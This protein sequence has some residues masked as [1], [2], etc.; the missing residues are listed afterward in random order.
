MVNNGRKRGGRSGIGRRTFIGAAGAGAVAT[1]FAGCLG[2]DDDDIIRI[3]HLGPVQM[4]MGAGA[5]NSA[6][7]AVDQVNEDGGILDQEVELISED[8]LGDP[9]ESMTATER[10][11]E[12]ENIDVLIGTFVSEVTQGIVD[13]VGEVDIPFLIT[14]SADPIT[15]TDTVGEDY[16][17]FKNI[18]RSGPINSDLQALG[19][20]DYAEFLADEHGWTDFAH[21]ADD[22]AWTVPFSENLP[23]ELEDRGL[24]V[25]HEDRLAPGTDDFSPMLSDVSDADAD[26]MLRF[27]A[28][29][30]GTGMLVN[31]R[32]NEYEFGIEGIH[33]PGMSPEFWDDSE[34]AC[35]YETTSQSGAAGAAEITEETVPFTEAYVEEYGDSRPSLPM[36]M[37]YNSYDAVFVYKNAVE[38]A[39][40]ADYQ[41]DIDTI[42]DELLET[43]HTGATGE[44]EFYG[45]DSEYP[46]DV[47]ETEVDGTISNF[48][49]TQWQED[50]EFECVFPRDFASA[51][52][53][54][55]DWM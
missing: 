18:F 54:A 55:P 27:F 26:A 19:M 44:I 43:D 9:G 37:G 4:D 38:R 28:H 52:H 14:G 6:Q 46:H 15:L 47:M 30:V 51:D 34:G 20:A 31:W 50:G 23:D 3:G 16:D 2:E 13:Y 39:G 48:P 42:V 5:E 17:Q 21:I 11:V 40:T 41:A 25:V 7:L 24:N 29:N 8:S 49:V 35:L 36:Y 32:E 22:A 1:T 10:M 33:V 53:L 12:Q 45:P